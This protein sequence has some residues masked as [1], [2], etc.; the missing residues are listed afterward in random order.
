LVV[1]PAT[2]RQFA[3]INDAAAATTKLLQKQ[4]ILAEYFRTLEDDD[5]RRAVRFAAGR[6]FAATDERVLNVGGALVSKVVLEILRLD[7]R[8]YR[9]LVVTSG[10]IG[11]GIAKVWDQ[12]ISDA[13]RGGAAGLSL[14]LRDVSDAFDALASTGAWESK[15][16]ILLEL[17]SRCEHP[18]EAA[19]LAKVIFGDLRTG[20][21]EGVLHDAIAKAFERDRPT[22]QRCQLLVGD[23]GEVAV[24]A[25]H[26]ACATAQFRLFHPIQFMLATPLED[27]T[28]AAAA[29]DGKAF[30]AEDKLDG[31]RAQVHKSG[32]VGDEARV[33]IYTRTMDRTDA[34]FP[35]VVDVIRRIPG[36][37]LLDGEIVPW[38]DGCVLP[39]AHIQKRLGRKVLTPKILRDNPA[40]FI[41]FDILYKDD[42]LLMDKPLRERRAVLE[43]L[44][45]FLPLPPGEGR[46]EGLRKETHVELPQD[47]SPHSATPAR[48]LANPL[49]EG[50]GTRLLT[51]MRV[52]VSTSEQIAAV[53]DAA[54]ERRN[55]GIIL[56]DPDSPYSPGRRGQMWFKLKTHLPTLDCVVTAAEYGHG[57][58]RS[59]LS[60]Y[61]FA[62]WDREPTED[63]ATLVNVGKAYSGVTDAE[64]AQLTELFLGITVGKFGRVHAVTPRV[65]LEIACDQ[66]Q[67]SNRHASGYALRFPRIK[68]IRWDK[69]PEDADRLARVVELHQSEANFGRSTR[70]V[71]PETPPDPTLFDLI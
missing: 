15:R 65:V 58:R 57:K 20:V 53:F 2:L 4:A 69:R 51:R 50:E 19:Y 52:E 14:A 36:E 17:F 45:R 47:G 29:L 10:E 54:R 43:T 7:P 12:R 62:V 67:A 23:L 44:G 32:G 8:E 35:D 18:R 16:S 11:E 41:A 27:A 56:K 25:K 46:G 39:F 33:A 55:E 37:F 28:E 38:C 40:A 31:I 66:I 42:E 30:Y 68:R 70:P 48:P 60:D 1:P 64:I 61:T 59:V 71:E 22:V 63:G 34:S 6:P 24:L 9:D 13:S 21:Q 26:D 3:E 49:P 5:L